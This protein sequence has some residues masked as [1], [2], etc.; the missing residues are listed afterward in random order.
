MAGVT[1][2]T[3]R[4]RRK[5]QKGGG[6]PGG[7]DGIYVGFTTGDV[8]KLTFSQSYREIKSYS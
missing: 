4:A 2:D 6:E 5:N 7:G 1:A 8:D 3:I